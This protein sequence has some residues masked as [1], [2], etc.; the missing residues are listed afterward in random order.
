VWKKRGGEV[1]KEE[2]VRWKGKV[3][4]VGEESE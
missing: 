3:G 1:G 4:E 2:W